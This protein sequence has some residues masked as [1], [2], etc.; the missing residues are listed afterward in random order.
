MGNYNVS[1]D[2]LAPSLV[3]NHSYSA[4]ALDLP[5]ALG[6]VDSLTATAGGAPANVH[7]NQQ[8]LHQLLFDWTT[9]GAGSGPVFLDG[10][11]HDT[12]GNASEFFIAVTF[13]PTG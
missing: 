7:F 8:N 5:I 9:P 2:S 13:P 10:K 12:G 11:V 4:L 6:S 3:A 1:W